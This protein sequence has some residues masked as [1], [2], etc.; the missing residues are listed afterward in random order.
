MIANIL[1]RIEVRLNTDYLKHK[2]E[3]DTLAY[4][5]V[6]TG[7]I[8]EYFDYKLGIL[9]LKYDIAKLIIQEII[10]MCTLIIK[11]DEDNEQ[12]YSL[13]EYEIIED[14]DKLLLTLITDDKTIRYEINSD[15]RDSNLS[16]IKQFI[17]KQFNYANTNRKTVIISEYLQRMYIF[18]EGYDNRRQFSARRVY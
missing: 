12:S 13:K 4:K 18:I 11:D 9:N 15:L 8:D 6:Y 17:I 3:L 16:S 10:L 2:E 14:D 1:E 7:P 5:V